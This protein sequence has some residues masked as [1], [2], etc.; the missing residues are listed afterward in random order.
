TAPPF[1]GYPGTL[2]GDGGLAL[3]LAFLSDIQVFMF[4]EAAQGDTRTNMLQAPKLTMFNGQTATISVTD[5]EFFLLGLQVAQA[6][7]QIFFVPQH[8]PG[9]I[10]VHLTVQPVVSA[11]RRFGRMTL[12]A[13]ITNLVSPNIPLIPVQVPVTPLFEVS[14]G[15]VIGSP[16]AI[17]TM[18][19]QQPAF[20]NISV[21]TTVSVPDGGTV[22]LGGLKTLVEA[23]NEFGVPVLSKIPYVN[24]LFRNVGYGPQPRSL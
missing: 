5:N 17:F 24:R 18:F 14:G 11:D 23:R 19:F 16:P 21:S 1:G 20:T 2:T 13:T 22:L 10:G 6:G 9:P 3:G 4:M 12:T 8:A 15:P 7:P